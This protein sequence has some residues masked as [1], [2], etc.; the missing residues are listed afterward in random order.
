M[1]FAYLEFF[2]L[3]LHW[4]RG[5]ARRLQKLPSDFFITKYNKNGVILNTVQ[6]QDH[7]P[8]VC[9]ICGFALASLKLGDDWILETCSYH[10]LKGLIDDLGIKR[11]SFD[12]WMRQLTQ[13][14]L[15]ESTADKMLTIDIIS[16]G[17]KAGPPPEA[18]ML[19]DMRFL[20]NPYWVDELRPMTGLDKPVQDY[21]L[22]QTLAKQFLVSFLEIVNIVLPAMKERD[23]KTFT[24]AFG[25]TG[26]QHRSTSFVE[27]VAKVLKEKLPESGYMIK[28]S[29]R[30]LTASES[31]PENRPQLAAKE[32]QP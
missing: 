30:E 18:N 31:M 15:L 13:F 28:L 22:E 6:T 25:C 21:V 2:D 17:Y 12:Q 29:H 11:Q 20:D 8:A 10:G 16:F 1:P 19:F 3:A 9:G 26:G 14:P 4:R 7:H 24:I 5:L 27:Y 23:T 32:Q